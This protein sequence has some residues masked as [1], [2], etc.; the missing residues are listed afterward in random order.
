[1]PE[2]PEKIEE[3]I[4]HYLETG[5]DTNRTEFAYKP[6]F[7]RPTKEELLAALSEEVRKREQEHP[8][9]MLPPGIDPLLLA[10]SK[11][12]ADGSRLLSSCGAR[13]CPASAGAVSNLF[14]SR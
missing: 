7:P 13:S 5:D 14:D 2:D 11:A 10:R 3:I 4:R 8:P 1:M 6:P 9:A 12:E